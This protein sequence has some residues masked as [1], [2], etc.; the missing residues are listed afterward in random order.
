M[1][2]HVEF[3]FQQQ[4]FMEHLYSVTKIVLRVKWCV[5][6]LYRILQSVILFGLETLFSNNKEK[7]KEARVRNKHKSSIFV[8]DFLK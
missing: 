3:I 2:M 6:V 5:A 7:W 8:Y 4:T 1:Q